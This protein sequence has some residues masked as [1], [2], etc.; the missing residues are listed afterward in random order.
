M[1]IYATFIDMNY[2]IG[3]NFKGNRSIVSA[4]TQQQ[5]HIFRSL[6]NFKQKMSL[7]R[8]ILRW[9]RKLV[10]DRA[11]NLSGMKPVRPAKL[12]WKTESILGGYA[13]FYKSS[14]SVGFM[15]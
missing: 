10:R 2:C 12:K 7:H 5:N 9:R 11:D 4:Y 6:K 13:K 15:F 1:Q 14:H 3:A 8:S